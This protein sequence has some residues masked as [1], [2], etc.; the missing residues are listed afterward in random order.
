MPKT[1]GPLRTKYQPETLS[2]EHYKG[3]K[4]MVLLDYQVK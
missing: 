4:E 1:Q 3:G 2:L